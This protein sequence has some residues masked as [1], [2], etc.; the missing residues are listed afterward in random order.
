MATERGKAL[1][2]RGAT[3]QHATERAPTLRA[4]PRVTRGVAFAG[5]HS[6]RIE[7]ACRERGAAAAVERRDRLMSR[8]TDCGEMSVAVNV[9]RPIRNCDAAWPGIARRIRGQIAAASLDAQG[10]TTAGE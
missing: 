8:G 1:S 7:A 10:H 3:L 9:D 6:R 4:A 5:I 2:W